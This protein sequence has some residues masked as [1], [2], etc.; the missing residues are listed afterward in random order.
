MPELSRIQFDTRRAFWD[1][2]ACAGPKDGTGRGQVGEV[3][4]DINEVHRSARFWLIRRLFWL[5]PFAKVWHF[6]QLWP[7]LVSK[8]SGCTLASENRFRTEQEKITKPQETWSIAW[9]LKHNCFSLSIVS[10]NQISYNGP[11]GSFLARPA[12]HH[13][14][15]LF[16][17]LPRILS[18]LS[19]GWFG[20]LIHISSR[21]FIFI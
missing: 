1:L 19:H 5:G 10:S 21:Y 13:V 12:S 11:W 6:H 20:W 14:P 16:D 2:I 17:S 7:W 4:A 15:A 8:V 3:V 18:K 9:N